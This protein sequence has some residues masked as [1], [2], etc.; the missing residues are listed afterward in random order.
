MNAVA[1]AVAVGGEGGG[2]GGEV[3]AADEVEVGGEGGEVVVLFIIAEHG[4]SFPG[5]ARFASVIGT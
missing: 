5:V 4:K 2:L 1:V 3:G